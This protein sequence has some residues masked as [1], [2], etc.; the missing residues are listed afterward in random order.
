M[1]VWTMMFICGVVQRKVH[2][3]AA[4]EQDAQSAAR[5][6]RE[7]EDRRAGSPVAGSPQGPEWTGHWEQVR[8]VRHWLLPVWTSS[9]SF[10]SLLFFGSLCCRLKQEQ[11]GELQR[12]V[13]D[14]QKALQSQA[15]KPDEVRESPSLNKGIK[16]SYYW[17]YE[18]FAFVSVC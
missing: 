16:Q 18:S 5:G 10:K 4:W 12:Q 2:Q 11:V 7:G 6:V 14:L 13:E 8:P 9:L 15:V 1:S 17:I 3:A